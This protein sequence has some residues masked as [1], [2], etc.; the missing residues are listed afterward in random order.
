MEEKIHRTGRLNPVR[1][2]IITVKSIRP[3]YLDSFTRPEDE[4]ALMVDAI[5]IVSEE[6]KKR[7]SEVFHLASKETI[8]PGLRDVT[9]GMQL[10]LTISTIKP[11]VG[12]EIL[13]EKKS[14]KKLKTPKITR[15]RIREEIQRCGQEI[16]H[17]VEEYDRRNP[18]PSGKTLSKI[19]N[20]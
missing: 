4:A 9:P 3:L 1:E 15:E 17:D 7:K 5:E 19:I 18:P 20:S 11:I 16:S 6:Q 14:G 2:Q 13:P 12:V 10:K 8:I